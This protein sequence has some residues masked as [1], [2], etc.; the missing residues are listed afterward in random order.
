MLVLGGS[1]LDGSTSGS[2]GLEPFGARGRRG[3]VGSAGSSPLAG[4][5]AAGRFVVLTQHQ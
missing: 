5:A 3:F 4:D 2:G 1:G